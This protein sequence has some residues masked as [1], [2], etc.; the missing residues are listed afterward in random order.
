MSLLV[1]PRPG[2]LAL[3]IA[4][5][6]L[7]CAAESPTPPPPSPGDPPAVPEPT[8][9]RVMLEVGADAIGVGE[10]TEVTAWAVD[11]EDARIEGLE[12]SLHVGPA[13]VAA[14]EGGQVVGIDEGLA[15][16]W[17]EFGDLESERVY[18]QVT[19]E[20]ERQA[21]ELRSI[22]DHVHVA[23]GLRT[24]IRLQA[25]DADGWRVEPEEI[26]WEVDD[27]SVAEIVD[28]EVLGVAPGWAWVRARAGG[29]WSNRIPVVVYGPDR[30]R[31]WINKHTPD[32]PIVVDEGLDL[33]F[34][35][36]GRNI[37]DLGRTAVP[38]E[39]RLIDDDTDEVLA[40][41]DSRS[42]VWTP[43]LDTST[44]D[45]GVV[46][47]RAEARWRS[48]TARR[49]PFYVTVQHA[50][51]AARA[52]PLLQAASG[53]S[54]S[55]RHPAG[56]IAT[57][58]DG[59]PWIALLGGEEVRVLQHDGVRWVGPLGLAQ[60]SAAAD[61]LKVFHEF[62]RDGATIYRRALGHPGLVLDSI[63]R[64]VLMADFEDDVHEHRTRPIVARWQA[65]G[66]HPSGEGGWVLLTESSVYRD[67]AY[68]PAD[69]DF[70]SLDE[71]LAGYAVSPAL[72]IDPLTDEPVA[73]SHDFGSGVLDLS[74]WRDARWEKRAPS[75]AATLPGTARDIS[76]DGS[77]RVLSTS[78]IHGT[79]HD[80]TTRHVHS[81]TPSFQR[82]D[83]EAWFHPAEPS[84]ITLRNGDL[85]AG[86]LVGQYVE[87]KQLLDRDPFAPVDQ[88]CARAGGGAI[89]VVWREGGEGHQ[90]LYAAK[91]AEGADRFEPIELDLGAALDPDMAN[92]WCAMND[93]G[94]AFVLF[95]DDVELQKGEPSSEIP[96]HVARF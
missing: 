47:I 20:R 11:R 84:I 4:L 2:P 66:A 23:A 18:V 81:T 64:P 32:E 51:R 87:P 63:G 25:R 13:H 82:V 94:E 71:R 28:G 42:S 92:L 83:G 89:F 3:A 5:A 68:I 76:F 45:E 61:E 46:A 41:L 62:D 49:A 85:Y 38:D 24:P 7:A 48:H 37:P 26:E 73:A 70:W 40:A 77:G 69:T 22:D 16:A 30:G 36:D 90:R 54:R 6:A 59:A 88:F 31:M 93:R 53:P 35:I 58:P 95:A 96:Y 79:D 80:V 44:W 74:V 15:V 19:L 75:A 57:G 78:Y 14:I 39:L 1:P 60:G 10:S 52:A 65:D 21:L 8:P 34:S 67:L 9:H 12:P 33:S 56:A 27:P 86:H 43:F 55:D 17:A 91:Q 29:P 72:T 50:D